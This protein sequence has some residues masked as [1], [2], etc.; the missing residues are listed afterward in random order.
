MEE[1]YEVRIEEVLGNDCR[2]AVDYYGNLDESDA[3]VSVNTVVRTGC[4]GR[5]HTGRSHRL[6]DIGRHDIYNGLR[7]N[8]VDFLISNDHPRDGNHH[9][10]DADPISVD[11]R[12][13]YYGR[14]D[15][16]RGMSGHYGARSAG[17]ERLW[18]G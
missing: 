10:V 2:W 8:D 11:A 13:P 3:D 16:R 6:L 1:A 17:R 12:H 9:L 15:D 5:P 7:P 4:L 18:F 14:M